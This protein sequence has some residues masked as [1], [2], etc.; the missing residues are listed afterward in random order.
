MK[1]LE[2]LRYEARP[3]LLHI[4]SPLAR[5]GARLEKQCDESLEIAGMDL[6][7]DS[8]GRIWLVDSKNSLVRRYRLEAARPPR[9]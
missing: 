2:G 4:Y 5:N 7:L 1:P 6:A 9:K 3:G 8:R